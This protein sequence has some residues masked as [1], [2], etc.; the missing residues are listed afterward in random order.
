MICK[1]TNLFENGH[2]K[3]IFILFLDHTCDRTA[4]IGNIRCFEAAY[5]GVVF[6]FYFSL[7][8]H[9][10]VVSQGEPSNPKDLRLTFNSISKI[11]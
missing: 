3:R 5:K 10:Y 7:N 2:I 9:L 6:G 1:E 4:K 8:I 11:M